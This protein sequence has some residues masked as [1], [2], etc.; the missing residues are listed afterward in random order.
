L[1]NSQVSIGKHK[2][3]WWVCLLANP[4]VEMPVM[5]NRCLPITTNFSSLYRCV[6]F[7]LLLLAIGSDALFSIVV[8]HQIVGVSV[9]CSIAPCCLCSG[10]ILCYFPSSSNPQK[11]RWTKVVSS[12]SAVLHTSIPSRCLV[13]IHKRDGTVSGRR[14]SLVFI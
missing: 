4:N 2:K 1:A 8:H 10:A 3:V 5:Q 13:N 9:F 14:L 7:S 12:C 6:L 11:V